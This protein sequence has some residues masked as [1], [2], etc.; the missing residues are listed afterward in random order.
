M[1]LIIFS[2]IFIG[3]SMID[4]EI[5]Y[6]RGYLLYGPAGPGKTSAITALAGFSFFDLIHSCR[7]FV[8]SG[9]F[10][11]SISTMN[12]IQGT[13]TDDRLQQLLS[14]VPE[15]SLI[16]SEDID[17]ATVGK[18]YELKVRSFRLAEID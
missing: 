8:P 9:H 17:A 16:L 11:L 15:E 1:T 2:P 4:R 6:R 12:S 3:T 10:E 14:H 18:H 5:P 7:S 13:M